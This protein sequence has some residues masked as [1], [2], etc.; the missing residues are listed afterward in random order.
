MNIMHVGFI[1]DG[2]RRW[3]KKGNFLPYF[4]HNMGGET[5]EKLLEICP[6]FNIT[7][8]TIY[9]LSSENLE[10]RSKAEVV[11]L[12]SLLKIM[13]ESKKEKLFKGGIRVKIAGNLKPFPESTSKALIELE[14]YTKDCKNSLLQICVN[15]GGRQ[16]IIEAVKKTLKDGED[17]NEKNIS[18]N[19]QAGGDP[20]LIIR[21]GGRQRLSNFLLWQGTYSELYF[22]DKLWPEFDEAELKKAIEFFESQER[23]F[24]K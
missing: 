2:N 23:N 6:K 14:D 13:A 22:S 4:G 8:V 20:D 17:I 15:Y 1:M 10:N 12:M 18:K 7:T 16:E 11:A 3:A 9:A 24:G 21:T 19:L 5:L